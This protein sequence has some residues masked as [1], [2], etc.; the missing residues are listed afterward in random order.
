M[1]HHDHRVLVP[2]PPHRSTP[3]IDTA[4]VVPTH[5]DTRSRGHATARE[6]RARRWRRWQYASPWSTWLCPR[7]R[8]AGRESSKERCSGDSADCR[9]PGTPYPPTAR[10]RR[11]CAGSDTPGSRIGPGRRRWC[12]GAVRSVNGLSTNSRPGPTTRRSTHCGRCRHRRP[13][14][15]T[16]RPVPSPP[17]RRHRQGSALSSHDAG[18]PGRPEGPQSPR[19]VGRVVRTVATARLSDRIGGEPLPERVGVSLVARPH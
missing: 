10:C 16:K 17:P 6:G 12:R 9:E 2:R 15:T 11:R 3:T 19:S 5:S 4:W 14:S 1:A 8:A 18:W 7:C 13:P